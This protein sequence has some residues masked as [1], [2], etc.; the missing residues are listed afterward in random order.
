MIF[1]TTVGRVFDCK[2]LMI[3]RELRI[4]LELTFAKLNLCIFFNTVQDQPIDLLFGPTSL[5]C[6]H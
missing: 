3:H 1:K 6:N 5:K 4:F 2:N